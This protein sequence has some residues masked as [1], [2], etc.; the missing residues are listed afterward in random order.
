MKKII[1]AILCVSLLA[2]IICIPVSATSKGTESSDISGFINGINELTQKYDADKDFEVTSENIVSE[3]FS[4]DAHLYYSASSVSENETIDE[5][6]LDFQ[7]C[8]LIV[9]SDVEFNNYGAVD[10]VSG[11]ENFHILQYKTEIDTKKAYENLLNDPDII[12]VDI[13]AVVSIDSVETTSTTTGRSRYTQKHFYNCWSLNATGMDKVLE[14]YESYDL[15]EIIVGVIDTG[16][17]L[18]HDI[19]KDRI[20]R[21]NFNSSYNAVTD[22]ETDVHGHGSMVASAIVKTTPKNVKVAVYKFSEDGQGTDL[23]ASIAILKAVDDGVKILNCSF[24]T[25]DDLELQKATLA[26]AVEHDCFISSAAGNESVNIS[27]VE[28]AYINSSDMVFSVG[29]SNKYHI[30]ASFT[31]FGTP[32]DILAPGQGVCLATNGNGFTYANGTSFSAPLVAGIY[33]MLT[34]VHPEYTVS[35]KYRMLS[36]SYTELTQKYIKNCFL[37]GVINALDLFEL[38]EYVKTPIIGL[39]SG[40]YEGKVSFEIYAEEGC[41]IYY[42]TDYTY[43]SPTNGIL[44]TQP[45]ELEGDY[46]EYTAVAYKDGCR[47]DYVK[48]NIHSAE[49]GTDEMFTISDDG[50]ITGYT[51]YSRYLKIPETINGIEVTDIAE[52]LFTNVGIYGIV[53][54]DTMTFLGDVGYWG[55]PTHNSF[56]YNNQYVKYISGENIKIIGCNAFTNCNGLSEVFFPNLEIVGYQPFE[57]SA[58]MGVNFPKVKTLLSNAFFNARYLREIYLPECT[59]MLDFA[60]YNCRSLNYLYA[61]HL[62]MCDESV[63]YPGTDFPLT[64]ICIENTFWS[65][66][67]LKEIDLPDIRV[68]GF[69]KGNKVGD[70]F[71]NFINS[72][73]KRVNYSKIEYIYDIPMPG[74]SYYKDTLPVE[75]EMVLPSTLRYSEPIEQFLEDGTRYYTVYGSSETYAEE[76]ANSNGVKFVALNAKTSIA[77]DIEPVWDKYSYKPLYFDARGFNRT[78]QWYGSYDNKIGNDVAIDGAT[79]NEFDPDKSTK[80][81]YYYCQMISTDIDNDGKIVSSFTVNSTLCQNR[82]YYMYAKDKTEIDV[83]NNLIFTKQFVCRDFFEIVHINENTNYLLTPSY[84]YQNN[85]WYGTGSQLQI[86]DADA[87][88]DITYILIVEGDT[89]G[90]SIV[91]VLDVANVEKGTNNHKELSGIYRLAGDSNRDGVFDVIDYQ[92]VVNRAM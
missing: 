12:S 61:P 32:V 66:Y 81:A 51:G 4:E 75:V 72:G 30:P 67:Y 54:P 17:D 74:Y 57:G 73:I 76:W 10:T 46:V 9:Q 91:D 11:F 56:I 85:C 78:Y 29:A 16:I 7:T 43:P 86:Q 59:E 34:C 21:T 77:E 64:D 33:A 13:D 15:P 58:I 79:T 35:E 22:D 55:G 90:D 88:T 39:E 70:T 24:V 69:E 18:D 42:T 41:E 26:Y 83:E 37:N 2:S 45:I 1:S 48:A 20:V 68:I 80:F 62:D 60:F 82:F 25:Q 40:I 89:N 84:E 87:P 47:S 6:E 31:N 71:G 65:T 50:I 63:E 19:F 28:S 53:L 27:Q 38:N 8:R 52:N 44:Y 3:N 14:Y 92:A 23:V 49:I 36:G 5:P